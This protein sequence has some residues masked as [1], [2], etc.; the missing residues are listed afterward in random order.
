MCGIYSKDGKEKCGM[1]LCC[2]ATGWCGVSQALSLA[3][4]PDRI[5]DSLA[6]TKHSVD[7]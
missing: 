3:L 5:S 2:S 1:N 7:D 4:E 6:F